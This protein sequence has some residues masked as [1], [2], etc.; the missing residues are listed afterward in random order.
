MAS[1]KKYK[2]SKKEREEQYK[3]SYWNLVAEIPALILTLFFFLKAL[4]TGFIVLWFLAVAGI[5]IIAIRVIRFFKNRKKPLT[6]S[7]KIKKH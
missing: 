6:K 2:V 4:Q 7:K 5:I 3:R 1:K